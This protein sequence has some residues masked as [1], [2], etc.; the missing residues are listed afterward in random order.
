M[1]EHPKGR[2][3]VL[4]DNSPAQLPI[5]QALQDL[6]YLTEYSGLSKTPPS[7]DHNAHAIVLIPNGSRAAILD[8][9]IARLRGSWDAPILVVACESTSVSSSIRL[10][11]PQETT[12][13]GASQLIADRLRDEIASVLEEAAASKIGLTLGL[14]IGIYS[15]RPDET[16]TFEEILEG[17]DRHMYAAKR[18]RNE[19]RTDDYRY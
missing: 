10:S 14:S 16:K 4:S 6:G 17:V 13:P 2:V 19:D 3:V 7:P 18:A 15:C 12:G 9:T 1:I 11:S 5:R 8:E